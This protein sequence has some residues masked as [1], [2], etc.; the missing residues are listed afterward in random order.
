MFVRVSGT[1]STIESPMILVSIAGVATLQAALGAA[2]GL[3]LGPLVDG[4]YPR[5]WAVGGWHPL[6]PSRPALEIAASLADAAG[7]DRA[8]ADALAAQPAPAPQGVCFLG[9]QG[10]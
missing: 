2:C 5:A 10:E 7:L 8:R 3:L 9:Q 6:R 1:L 4:A